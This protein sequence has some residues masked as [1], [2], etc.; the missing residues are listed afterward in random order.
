MKKQRIFL[1][2]AFGSILAITGCG[3][4]G[5]GEGGSGGSAGAGGSAGSGG[6]NGGGLCDPDSATNA[7]TGQCAFEP[8]SD[9][10]CTTA[11]QN[12]AAICADGCAD[13]C[14]GLES[15]PAL[16]GAACEGTRN[17]QC[18]NLVF[19]CFS[20]NDTCDGVGTCVA[21]GAGL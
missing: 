13:G 5:D 19:G 20:Q 8:P 15:D 16:C 11:C 21:D 12:V 17:L 14:S 9:I 1:A 4:D 3:G 2:I 18:T 10:N 7:C 6:S